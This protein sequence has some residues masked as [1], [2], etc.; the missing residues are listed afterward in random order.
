MHV[1]VYCHAGSTPE[2]GS[3]SQGEHYY[4][5]LVCDSEDLSSEE[6]KE[7][8]EM[9]HRFSDIISLSDSDI[10]WENGNDSTSY[11]HRECKTR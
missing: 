6:R 3:R 2:V 7:L 1:F 10:A 8:K 5:R 9:L 4:T 11:Q